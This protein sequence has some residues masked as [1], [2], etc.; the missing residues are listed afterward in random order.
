MFGGI[1]PVSHDFMV[2]GIVKALIYYC[3]TAT[4]LA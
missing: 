1:A 4:Y 2:K 3:A